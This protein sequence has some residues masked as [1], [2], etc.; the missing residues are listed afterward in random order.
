MPMRNLREF[1][2]IP[3]DRNSA[4][5]KCGPGTEELGTSPHERLESA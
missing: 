3:E 4:E 1:L 5:A 2:R